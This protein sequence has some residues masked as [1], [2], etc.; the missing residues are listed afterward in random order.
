MK[1]D[2]T[3]K[4]K[5]L[6]MGYMPTSLTSDIGAHCIKREVY[7]GYVDYEKVPLLITIMMT[8]MVIPLQLVSPLS[9]SLYLMNHYLTLYARNGPK[10]LP[11][12]YVILPS[13]PLMY[14]ILYLEKY[15]D[16][17]ARA[18]WNTE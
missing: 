2:F 1:G 8:T 6:Y 15:I 18:E 16:S 9:L 5:Q 11:R 10:R 17:F 3:N 14:F 13:F 7:K 12:S 4:I